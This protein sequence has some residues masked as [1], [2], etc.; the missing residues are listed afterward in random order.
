MK[1]FIIR[2]LIFISPIIILL[3]PYFCTDPFKVLR[4]YDLYTPENGTPMYIN[5]NRTMVSTEMFI[6]NHPIYNYNSFIFGSSR[7]MVYRVNDW[8][9][10]LPENAICFH[11]DGYGESLYLVHKKIVYLKDKA[12]ISNVLLPLDYD[13]LYQIKPFYTPLHIEHPALNDYNNR[14]LF[15]S[16]YIKA[17]LNTT[18]LPNYLYYLTTDSVTPNMIEKGIIDTVPY[19]Y[20]EMYNE[21]GCKSTYINPKIY[22]PETSIFHKRSNIQEYYPQVIKSEQKKLLEEIKNIFEKHST[23]YCIV[24]NPLYNQKKLDKKDILYLDSLFNG[25]IYDFS[26][27]NEITSEVTNYSDLNHFKSSVAKLILDSIYGSLIQ[28]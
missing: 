27:I 4:N 11:F 13:L 1:K 21:Y 3:L 20:N 18:F 12:Q 14:F 22:E 26:G 6:K 2:F 8:S 15:Q 5:L 17:Y 25:N 24:I 19:C 7:S 10:Y 28:H 16:T 9:K 23:N